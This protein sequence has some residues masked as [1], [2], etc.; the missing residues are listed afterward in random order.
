M[1][2]L[3][4]EISYDDE[5]VM[6]YQLLE[7]YLPL[8]FYCWNSLFPSNEAKYNMFIQKHKMSLWLSN[9]SWCVGRV[10]INFQALPTRAP[11]TGKSSI[12]C[13]SYPTP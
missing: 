5:K 2:L 1:L 12:S 4:S 8:L 3:Q 11:E 6:Y 10:H 7:M 9:M 13:C